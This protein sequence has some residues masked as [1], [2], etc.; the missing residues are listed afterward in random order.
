MTTAM[1]NTCAFVIKTHQVKCF[2]ALDFVNKPQEM[3]TNEIYIFYIVDSEILLVLL[4]LSLC[5]F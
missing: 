5:H 4:F 3:L 1:E 2:N